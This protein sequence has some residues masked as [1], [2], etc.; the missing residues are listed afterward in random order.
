MNKHGRWNNVEIAGVS[1]EIPNQDLENIIKICEDS[2]INIPHMDTEG[3][4]TSSRKEHS[5][6]N[7]TSH[8][9]IC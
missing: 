3:C 6:H 1:N 7:K 2:D 5:Q 4:K 8:Y 9:K